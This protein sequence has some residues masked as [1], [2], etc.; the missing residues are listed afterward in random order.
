MA[1]EA[2]FY[3]GQ[4]VLEGVMMRGRD[5]W[6]IAVRRPDQTIHIE[7]HDIKSVGDRVRILRKPFLRG[8]IALGQALSIGLRALTI[9]ANQSGSGKPPRLRGLPCVRVGSREAPL[10][11]KGCPRRRSACLGPS[12]PPAV[13]L[14]SCHC[15]DRRLPR[16]HAGSNRL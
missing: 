13:A 16:G 6:A 5:H 4:A 3:G 7:S 8:V 14:R 11:P 10:M 15:A 12:T 1:G 9:S 2:H